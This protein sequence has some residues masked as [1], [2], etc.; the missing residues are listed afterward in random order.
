MTPL[1]LVLSLLGLGAAYY[2]LFVFSLRR[3]KGSG[4][5][6]LPPW[7]VSTSGWFNDLP[8]LGAVKPFAIDPRALL[9][10]AEREGDCFTLKLFGKRMTFLASPEGHAHWFRTKEATFDIFEAYRFT[11]A[12][13][14]EDVCYGAPSSKIMH[15]QFG[16]FRWGLKGSHYATYVAQI[17]DEARDYFE[18]N[19]GEEGEADLFSALNEVFTLT[20]CRTLLGPEVRNL[21]KAEYGQYYQDLD[22]SFIPI[23]FFF[24]NMPH[25]FKNK[26]LKARQKFTELF[27]EIFQRRQASGE[28]HDDFL[29]VLL[30]SR[31]RDGR[32]MTMTEMT[33]IMIGTL[34]GGQHTSN[35]TG[36]W[37]LL[38]LAL[39][40]D[41]LEQC[42]QEQ[43]DVIGD[44]SAHATFE[45]LRKTWRL[46]I[47][48]KE[49]L[50]LHPPFFLLARTVTEDTPYKDFVIPKGDFV[51]VS[52]SMSQRL[53]SVWGEDADEFKPERFLPPGFLQDAKASSADGEEKANDDDGA[54]EIAHLSESHLTP[55]SYIPFGGGRHGCIGKKFAQVQIRTVIGY[56][57]RTYKFEVV[58]GSLPPEDYTTMVVTPKHPWPLRFR[59][60]T[61]T[62]HD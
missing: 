40:P 16:F 12:T 7:F 6:V 27:T 15:E 11:L 44:E 43:L 25:P 29:Q 8:F 22:K 34:L 48:L 50:R 5:A 26:C 14:G 53:K 3:K 60:R 56:L 59:K 2:Y 42:Y 10:E 54:Q 46:D 49:T 36:T 21:W 33:G 23:M 37:L 47:A 38:N 28:V 31:Y 32:Q 51:C 19:W 58:K 18:K 39:H 52:P 13:F 24:P 1:G 17:E 9:L 45:Q 62:T 57:I 61:P 4:G 20:S 55:H 35:V 41:R 30:N